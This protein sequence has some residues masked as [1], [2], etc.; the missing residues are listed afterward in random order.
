MDPTVRENCTII[1]RMLPKY[2]LPRHQ[3]GVNHNRGESRPLST[4][5]VVHLGIAGAAV[6]HHTV[7]NRVNVINDSWGKKNSVSFTQR[8]SHCQSR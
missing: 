2:M 6:H 1:T 8:G 5:G 4:F 3:R 7:E